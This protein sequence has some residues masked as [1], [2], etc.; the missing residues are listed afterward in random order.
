VILSAEVNDG[1]DVEKG[2]TAVEDFV[3]QNPDLSMDEEQQASGA[4]LTSMSAILL[5]LSPLIF[6]A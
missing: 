4:A 1:Y 2:K 6:L 5:C 3:Q